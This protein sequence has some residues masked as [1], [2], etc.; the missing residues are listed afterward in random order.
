MAAWKDFEGVILGAS[1]PL[2]HRWPAKAFLH[3]KNEIGSSRRRVT[4]ILF[5]TT[6][7]A[8]LIVSYLAIFMSNVPHHQDPLLRDLATG[9]GD[10]PIFT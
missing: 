4:S 9:G 1:Q 2:T 8:L 6:K 3:T 7:L 5:A 10:E